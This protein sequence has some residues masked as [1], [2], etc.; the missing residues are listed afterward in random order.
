MMMEYGTVINA[1]GDAVLSA[2]NENSNPKEH[3]Q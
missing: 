1:T 3:F 2:L